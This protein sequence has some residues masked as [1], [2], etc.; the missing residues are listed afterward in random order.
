MPD[1]FRRNEFR[2]LYDPPEP[3]PME[4]KKSD[5]EHH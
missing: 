2:E 1:G 5:A 4:P 3:I